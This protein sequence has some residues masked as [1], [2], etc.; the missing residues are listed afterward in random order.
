[1]TEQRA[2]IAAALA[3]ACLAAGIWTGLA[4]ASPIDINPNGDA[5]ADYVAISIGG[6]ANAGY[7]GGGCDYTVPLPTQPPCLGILA[8]SADGEATSDFLA[9]GGAVLL[10]Q[11]EA[12][13][14]D[15]AGG[16]L[17][18]PGLEPEALVDGAQASANGELDLAQS[19]ANGILDSAQAATESGQSIATNL[20]NFGQQQANGATD[21]A[22]AA[23]SAA[24]ADPAGTANGN[25][26]EAQAL[27]QE[28]GDETMLLAE[29]VVADTPGQ[30]EQ[31]VAD[32][33]ALAAAYQQALAAALDGAP[34]FVGA[35][36]ANLQDVASETV[37]GLPDE[38]VQADQDVVC[39]VVA[40]SGTGAATACQPELLCIAVSGTGPAEGYF[41]ISGTGSASACDPGTD[42]VCTAISLAGPAQSDDY[43]I[44]VL[45]DAHGNDVAVSGTGHAS[46]AV[47]VSGCD[48]AGACL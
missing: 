17:P 6:D 4:A 23:A 46:G 21:G 22:Q 28:L 1:M 44:S 42:Y 14:A 36:L 5:N 15:L 19:I 24:A 43:A 41:A 45:G 33:Q 34:A 48:L 13:V 20:V 26:A 32:A 39:H 40:V 38:C 10:G 47:A 35:A 3:V 11:V 30:I 16:C 9:I 37:A 7:A 25:V 12:C 29:D 27:V 8:V 31:S 2:T 18:D